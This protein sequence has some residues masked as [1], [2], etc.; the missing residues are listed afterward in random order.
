ML[1][2]KNINHLYFEIQHVSQTNITIIFR[3]QYNSQRR[4]SQTTSTPNHIH[5]LQTVF[6][7]A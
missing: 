2:K 3:V 4:K 7:Q 5:T 1:E 6:F